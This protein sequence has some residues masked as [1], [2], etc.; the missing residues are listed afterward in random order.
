[1]TQPALVGREAELEAIDHLVAMAPD[2]GGVLVLRGEAGIGKSA[3]LAEAVAAASRSGVRVLRVTGIRTEANLPF[4][5]LH[6]LLRPILGGL[7]QLPAPQR[8]ALGAAFGL[9][10]G[11]SADPFLISLATL[12]LLTDAAADRPI[13]AVVDDAQWLDRPTDEVLAFVARRL[14]SDPVA[15]LAA[16]LD[17]EATFVEAAGMPLLTLRPLDDDAARELLARAGHALAPAVRERMVREAAGNPLAL[18]ELPAA[19]PADLDG[20]AVDTL[21]VTARVEKAFAAKVVDLPAATSTLL[22]VAAVED[23]GSIDEIL[24]AGKALGVADRGIGSLTPAIDAGLLL[25]DDG[26]LRFRHPLIRS[27]IVQRANT[28]E[29]CAAH[30]ALADVVLDPDRVAWHRAAAAI[31]PDEAVALLLDAAA[32]RADRRSAV[33]VA[34]AALERAARLSP[35]SQA[36]GVRLL[37]AADRAYELGRPDIM[38]RVLRDAEP[39]DV[40]ALEDRRQA[41]LLALELNGPKT[42]REE[43]HIRQV[44]DAAEHAA[45]DGHVDLGMALLLLAAARCWWIDA[46]ADLR[47][48]VVEIAAAIAP[49]PADPRLLYVRASSAK[50][51][52][53][54]VVERIRRRLESPEP[55]QPGDARVLAT[56]AMW[57]G[58]LDTARELFASSVAAQRAQGRL[59]LV[60][61]AQVLSGW[62]AL[63]VGRLSDVAPALDEGLRL[64]GETNQQ[65]IVT[66]AHTA[67]AQ[68]HALR[69]DLD[70]GE[71]ALVEAERV[72]LETPADGLFANICHAH[73]M[74]DLAA[75]RYEEAFAMVRHIYEPGD[76][77]YHTVVRSWVVS[78]LVDAAIPSG[79]GAEAAGYLAALEADTGLMASPWQRISMAYARAVLAADGD[80]SDSAE[81]AFSAAFVPELQRWQL[82]RARLLLAYGTWLRRQRRVVESRTPLRT[83]RELFDAMGVAWMGERARRELGASGESSRARG[84]YTLDELTPQ[85]LQIARLAADG[86]S[87]R[88]IGERLYLS[89]RTVGFHLYHVYPKLGISSRAQLHAALA[90]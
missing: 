18:V 1:L 3:L 9:T 85:E 31:G 59:G 10:D 8:S 40:P 69:G 62:S 25:I 19:L 24:A 70:A 79:H 60:A 32:E 33:A 30:N 39:L 2:S 87:N 43:A 51:H 75:G 38:A 89:H 57:I 52:G 50:E 64:A 48:R 45:A 47:A 53:T 14:G 71:A 26:T 83:A 61:R 66:T 17:G 73:G 16:V 13:L 35:D 27:A 15:L 81:A 22:L 86:L 58:D 28:A 29:R 11:A 44:A 41:W 34:A 76:R 37:R 12:T 5:G 88:E 80:D 84:A 77:G 63:H 54:E 21:P 4:A 68:Y 56:A 67:W 65:F 90:G 55:I 78:D 36:R 74:L 42:V 20:G 7:D 72:A 46:P 82:P 6:Q 49:D 23:Q